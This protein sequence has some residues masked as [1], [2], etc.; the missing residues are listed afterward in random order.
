M[1]KSNLLTLLPILGGLFGGQTAAQPVVADV[2]RIVS[3]IHSIISS[4]ISNTLASIDFKTLQ[5][6]APRI[7]DG[8]TADPSD[9]TAFAFQ[10]EKVIEKQFSVT[11]RHSL[12][13]DNR[14]GKVSVQNWNRDEV[15]V[16]IRIRTAEN[17]ERRAQEAL[18]RVHIA[19]S[20]SDN[21]IS[22]KTQISSS[23][24]NWWSSLTSG[25]GD[26]ALRIDYAVYMPKGNDLTLTNKY[27]PVELADRDGRVSLSVSYGS[28]HTGR[29]N[30]RNNSLT[31]AYSKGV[32]DYLREGEVTVRYGGI[33]LS[34]SD[35]LKLSSSYSDGEIG[36]INQAADVEVRYGSSFR[37]GLGSDI[38]EVNVNA[39]YAPVTIEPSAS[40]DF[41]FSVAI[42]YG[43]FDYDNGSVHITSKAE[44]TTSKSYTGYWN[45]SGSNTVNINSRYGA[46]NLSKPLP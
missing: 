7:M 5:K 6:E 34:E 28:L 31:V 29:L 21:V 18:D 40:A 46:V 44:G 27:G 15:K 30:G 23:D 45:R 38:K 26:R 14:Y 22:L 9:P 19:E 10:K 20:R 41:N 25:S 17:A 12:S 8:T 37:M 13:I 11:P 2:E 1:N 4:E 32:I 43:G 16:T 35:R 42:S 36:R 33:R 39:A 24:A 3:D